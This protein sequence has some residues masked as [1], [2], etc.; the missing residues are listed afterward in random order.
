MSNTNNI[1]LCRTPFRLKQLDPPP[2]Y[3]PALILSGAQDDV[4]GPNAAA[5]AAELFMTCTTH[6]FED[7][8]RPLPAAQHAC[9]D[10]MQQI[11]TF[12]GERVGCSTQLTAGKT[13]A[14]GQSAAASSSAPMLRTTRG[15]NADASE[16]AQGIAASMAH[17]RRWTA[18]RA[19]ALALAG[20][21]NN[22]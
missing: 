9:T 17:Q 10:A 19:V 5:A 12:L 7:G 11:A 21:G 18:E 8:H 2:I 3:T 4:V 16:S 1:S 15:D 14:T 20:S 13:L 6:S 22:S